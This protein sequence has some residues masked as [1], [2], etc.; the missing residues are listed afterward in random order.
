VIYLESADTLSA[1]ASV[2][3]TITCTIYGRPLLLSTF[4]K[5]DQRQL[6]TGTQTLYTSAGTETNIDE[7]VLVNPTGSAAT[8]KLWHDGV[9]NSNMILPPAEIGPGEFAIYDDSG[10]HFY[11]ATGQLK[12]TQT[13]IGIIGNAKI[14]AARSS[15]AV[16][17]ANSVAENTLATYTIPGGEPVAGDVYTLDASGTILNNTGAGVTYTFRLKYGATTLMVTPALSLTNS[18][19]RRRWTV[20]AHMLFETT[21]AEEMWAE[22]LGTATGISES[23][24]SLGTSESAIGQGAAAESSATGKAFALTCQ[25]G[26]A[27]A[28]ADIFREAY[29]FE[30]HA[31]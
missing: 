22:L 31:V 25:M 17:F 26:T 9:A 1:E 27:N 21:S 12:V 30:R 2:A 11:T 13:V 24:A 28:L 14:N 15:S 6:A 16:S 29:V 4:A 10:W 3:S 5:L 20:K 19:V 23:W 8:V 7:I 18:S